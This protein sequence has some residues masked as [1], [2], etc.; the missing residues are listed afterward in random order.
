MP[1]QGFAQWT[2]GGGCCGTRRVFA[3]APSPGN[4]FYY[5]GHAPAHQKKKTE[6]LNANA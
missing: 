2:I 4:M 6:A 3:A 5:S 1:R